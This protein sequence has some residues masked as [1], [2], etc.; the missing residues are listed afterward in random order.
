MIILINILNL[1]IIFLLILRLF[2]SFTKQF[3]TF[4][5]YKVK[6]EKQLFVSVQCEPTTSCICSKR[7]TA[8]PR[9]PHGREQTTPRQ[10][11]KYYETNFSRTAHFTFYY[12]KV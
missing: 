7:L 5:S 1:T 6:Y 10:M 3:F 11:L 9:G 4:H 2:N 8:K 12:I